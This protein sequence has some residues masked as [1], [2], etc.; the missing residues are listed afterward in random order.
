MENESLAQTVSPDSQVRPAPSF[1]SLFEVITDRR[2]TIVEWNTR[3][4]KL[5]YNAA[6]LTPKREREWREISDEE[7]SRPA[8]L[9]RFICEL[10]LEWD[11]K[12]PPKDWDRNAIPTEADMATWESYPLT[13]ETLEVL[14]TDFLATCV[15][16]ITENIRPNQE[17][18][19]T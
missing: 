5:W 8:I 11:I 12:V 15:N 13:Q 2:E 6:L 7:K 17:R 4:F 19:A 1:V 18:S 9:A 16:A 10:A 3:S 14:P